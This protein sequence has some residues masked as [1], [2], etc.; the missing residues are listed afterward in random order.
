MNAMRTVCLAMNLT[1]G[2]PV[3][4][5]SVDEQVFAAS[6]G[7]IAQGVADGLLVYAEWVAPDGHFRIKRHP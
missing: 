1:F 7:S 5:Y 2:R 6:I 4:C 3:C